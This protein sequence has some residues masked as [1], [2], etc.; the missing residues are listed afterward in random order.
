ECTADDV[1]YS[2]Q[3][4]IDT[5]IWNKGLQ[6]IDKISAPDKYTVKFDMKQPQV[7][8][9]AIVASPYYTIFAKENFENQ[10]RF[11]AQPIGTGA[12]IMKE[13]V[14]QDHLFAVRNP[15]FNLK[16]SWMDAKY[17]Q[18]PMPFIEEFRAPYFASVAAAQSAFI[19]NQLDDFP[20][21][22]LDPAQ[23][24][25]ILNAHPQTYVTVNPL[26]ATYPIL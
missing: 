10:D 8:F 23:L 12:F 20:I 26:W 4:Y 15:T 18:T 9:D 19:A 3:R 11:K 7:T 24:K 17:Q 14:Y 22:Y 16:P 2:F 1:V 13:N 21:T 5:S 6:Y 25:D